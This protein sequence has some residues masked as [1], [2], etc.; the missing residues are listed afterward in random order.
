MNITSI[1]LFT[2]L[3]IVVGADFLF[4]KLRKKNNTDILKIESKKELKE[5]KKTIIKN[6]KLQFLIVLAIWG[7]LLIFDIYDSTIDKPLI[8]NYNELFIVGIVVLF[9]IVFSINA[10]LKINNLDSKKK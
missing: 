4:T 2:V 5:T 7:L 8:Y 1:L 9:Y 3:L 10:S 6:K